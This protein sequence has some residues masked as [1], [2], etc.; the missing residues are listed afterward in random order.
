MWQCISD[1]PAHH[2]GMRRHLSTAERVAEWMQMA[3]DSADIVLQDKDWAVERVP[4]LV[5]VRIPSTTWA[6]ARVTEV[7]AGSGDNLSCRLVVEPCGTML[8]VL[9]LLHPPAKLTHLEVRV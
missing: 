7:V 5:S 8:S 6:R 9:L 2:A 4:E 1:I 3:G